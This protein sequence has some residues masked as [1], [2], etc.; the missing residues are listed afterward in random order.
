[1][2]IVYSIY[3]IVRCILDCNDVKNRYFNLHNKKLKWSKAFGT[4]SLHGPA[5]NELANVFL[6]KSLCISMQFLPKYQTHYRYY[7]LCPF[8]PNILFL[9]LINTGINE[10][11][12]YSRLYVVFCIV[13]MWKI[14]I[15]MFI[16]KN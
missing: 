1:M 16:T 6:A 5:R 14:D 13:M 4:L 2:R 3:L 9:E 7:V 11:Y 10:N 8:N 15:L 12:L